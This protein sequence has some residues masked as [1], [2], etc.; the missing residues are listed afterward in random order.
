MYDD[1]TLSM[2]MLDEF[3]NTYTHAREGDDVEVVLTV[4]ERRRILTYDDVEVVI[5]CANRCSISCG[6]G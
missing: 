5:T 4:V 2:M 6:A 1:V 3:V